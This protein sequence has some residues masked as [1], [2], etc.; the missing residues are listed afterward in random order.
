MLWSNRNLKELHDGRC[1]ALG[2]GSV[3]GGAV[4]DL[5]TAVL[6]PAMQRAVT[7]SDAAGRGI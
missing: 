5:P 3:N 6:A 1:N 7:V 2:D 4:A